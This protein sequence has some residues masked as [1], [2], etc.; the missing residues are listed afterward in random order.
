MLRCAT[1]V[2]VTFSGTFTCCTFTCFSYTTFFT[3]R[4]P[5]RQALA[6]PRFTRSFRA[7]T[8]TSMALKTGIVGLPNVGKSTMFNALVVRRCKLN[9][10]A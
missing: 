5:F 9:T 1:R 8:M 7:S 10:S 4:F 2:R 6:A 3:Y